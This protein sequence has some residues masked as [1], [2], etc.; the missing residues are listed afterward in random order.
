MNKPPEN[1]FQSNCDESSPQRGEQVFQV[2]RADAP[3]NGFD[4]RPEVLNRREVRR[5]RR[6]VDKP[7]SD[8]LNR[9][10]DSSYFMCW[11]I[12]HTLAVAPAQ[13]GAVFRSLLPVARR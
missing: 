6:Q 7:R 13:A 1:I 11:H 4:L 3:Q 9:F 2:T 8:G 5:I 10:F 12:V